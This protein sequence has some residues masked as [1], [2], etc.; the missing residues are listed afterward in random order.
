MKVT[1]RNEW[2]GRRMKTL[3]AGF[4]NWPSVSER[5]K[6][7]EFVVLF[8]ESSRLVAAMEKA[9]ALSVGFMELGM[10]VGTKRYNGA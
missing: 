1:T 9:R 8:F 3:G 7:V 10:S 6:D 5:E 2:S 4:W